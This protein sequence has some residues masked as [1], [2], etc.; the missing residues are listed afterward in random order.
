MSVSGCNNQYKFVLSAG[1]KVEERSDEIPP[2]RGKKCDKQLTHIVRIRFRINFKTVQ[3][4]ENYV[5]K[6]FILSKRGAMLSGS[7]VALGFCR[8]WHELQMCLTAA[9]RTIR[10]FIHISAPLK[11]FSLPL[12]SFASSWLSTQYQG[13]GN[14][15][16]QK[17]PNSVLFYR[18]SFV[19]ICALNTMQQDK[20]V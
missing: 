7:F 9:G 2:W 19:A 6:S 14:R 17:F 1:V 5:V 4:N 8:V 13:S 16:R 10:N 20:Q 11:G 18:Q 3:M 15:L 12:S